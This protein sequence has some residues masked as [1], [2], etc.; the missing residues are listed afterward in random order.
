MGIG[1]SIFLMAVGAIL[2]WAVDFDLGGVEIATIGWILMAV[3][4]IGAIAGVIMGR[5]TETVVE[6]RRSY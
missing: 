5:R 6:D 2:V 3:G 4:V 1:A